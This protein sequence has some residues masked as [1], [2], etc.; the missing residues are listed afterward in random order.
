MK[1]IAALILLLCI[2][3]GTA[4]QA[5]FPVGVGT[6][7]N[8][9]GAVI[10]HEKSVA[11]EGKGSLYINCE[12]E[13]KPNMYA[14]ITMRQCE[15]DSSKKYRLS[16]Y[17]KSKDGG[18]AYFKWMWD[19]DVIRLGSNNDCADWTSVSYE[20]TPPKN[21]NWLSLIID[22][23]CNYYMDNVSIC[24]IDEN[25]VE[26]GDNLMSNGG[27]EKGDFEPCGDVSEVETNP[28][29]SA[30]ELKWKNPLDADFKQVD[31]YLLDTETSEETFIKT[32]VPEKENGV[33][34]SYTT[35]VVDGL[36]NDKLYFFKLYAIDDGDNMPNGVKTFGKPIGDDYYITDFKAL[37]GGN[38]I[39]S[40]T[41]GDIRI[42]AEF[43]NNK[44]ADGMIVRLIS[45]LYSGDSLI[46]VSADEK[47]AG[48]DTSASLTNSITVPETLDGLAL[49]SFIWDDKGNILHNSLNLVS[50]QSQ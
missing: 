20:F 17:V 33:A 40:L 8:N 46:A 25:G 7:S 35:A 19:W 10:R 5:A 2:F 12:S 38:E 16:F 6:A 4:A 47:Q 32:V 23:K 14:Y 37:S 44:I 43:K 11:Y 30:V 18:R 13:V 22:D 28:L 41:S 49:Y 36:E 3:A 48:K 27:F 26:I 34:Q 29:D 24:E 31:I 21:G 42:S 45:V 50:E 9:I 15:L 1:R 39:T